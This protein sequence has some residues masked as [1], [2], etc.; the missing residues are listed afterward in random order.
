MEDKRISGA[1]EKLEDAMSKIQDLHI[2]ATVGNITR[3]L[4]SINDLQ[5]VY[6]T[7]TILQEEQK[8]AAVKDDGGENGRETNTK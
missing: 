4:E 7:L 2:Q 3:I 6:N 1:Q 8:K 5:I